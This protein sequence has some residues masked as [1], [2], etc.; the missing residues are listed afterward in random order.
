MSGHPENGYHPELY[1]FSEKKFYSLKADAEFLTG[2]STSADIRLADMRYSRK[3]FRLYQEEGSWHLEPMSHNTSTFLNAKKITAA[4][5]LEHCD[6]IQVGKARFAFATRKDAALKQVIR[7][8]NSHQKLPLAGV[9][10]SEPPEAMTVLHN[11]GLTAS[12]QT[13]SIDHII[14][15][16]GTLILGRDRQRANFTL[17]HAQV[18]RQHALIESGTDR[19][20]ITDMN[21]ANG[22]Y[23]NG[24]RISTPTVLEPG[25]RLDIGPYSLTFDG[26]SL[27]PQT[28]YDNV[29]LACR[30]LN[31]VVRSNS[32]NGL[33][34]ILEDINIVI[35][36]REFVCILG[37]SGSG[38]ST[39][40]SALSARRP[41]E[42]SVRLNGE[43]LYQ[44]FEMFKR[45]IA[46]VPQKDIMHD[47]LKLS[48][49][50]E[51][52]AKLRLPPD[53]N[54]EE[55]DFAV[56]DMLERMGLSERSETKIKD[57][58]GGQV[59]RASLANEIV[60]KP[61]LLF[62]DEVTS[63]LDDQ[64]DSEMMKLFRQLADSGKTVVCVTHN[65]TYV[66]DTCH[67]V[68]VLT[69][70]G[71]LAFIGSPREA[72]EYFEVDRL[73]AIYEKMQTRSPEE[74]RQRFARD[75]RYTEGVLAH[76]DMTNGL[77]G[78]T[79]TESYKG[80]FSDTFIVFIRQFYLLTR[81][82]SVI[83]RSDWKSLCM[84]MGQCSL[85]GLLIVLLFGDVSD[86]LLPLR[87]GNT[88]QIMFL[89]CISVLWFGC[90]NSAKEIVKERELFERERAVNVYAT[91]YLGSKFLLLCS[92]SMLQTA[93]L[94]AIVAVGTSIEATTLTFLMLISLSVYGVTLGLL[95][96]SAS[97]ST[98]MAVT[99]VPLVLIPQIILSGS[100][101]E[102][103]GAA[104]VLSECFVGAYWGY[105]GLEAS[106]PEGHILEYYDG[107]T[108]QGPLL[109]I[110]LHAFVFLTSALIVLLLTKS[111]EA[112]YAKELEKWL[113]KGKAGLNQSL[114]VVTGA[115]K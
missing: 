14:P 29:E 28:R 15:L 91:S 18:S 22:T 52:T 93:L 57:L 61:S 71:K 41:A 31:K 98:D 44:N 75:T 30:N 8:R 113:F 108:F 99:T 47:H 53:L 74:W 69:R 35:H 11:E 80:S 72:C 5:R 112:S 23:V 96:S 110:G 77:R 49:A 87:N 40:L 54:Q 92:I 59:K 58:S 48:V 81:R 107:W 100:I 19:C 66:P 1:D 76:L 105:G 42:G 34:R 85:V 82:Y 20:R 114:R 78:K 38:K 51:Y 83:M 9:D 3:Q 50:L 106:L 16:T 26:K 104:L 2:R 24:K 21:S 90:N 7:G 33:T 84:I 10:K 95:I 46:V 89:M 25:D 86:K 103:E 79:S 67:R 4:R 88:A 12:R 63:G 36:P 32:G 102:V 109:V 73:G 64:T 70:G 39:L 101:F 43:E 62:L 97:Q 115:K 17:P 37:P 60:S 13:E 45:D 94:F 65:L 55:I 27:L 68:I 6:L 111:K 56:S